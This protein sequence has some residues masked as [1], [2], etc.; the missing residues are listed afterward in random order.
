MKELFAVY[1]ESLDQD[2]RVFLNRDEAE[3]HMAEL[4][5]AGKPVKMQVFGSHQIVR[6]E[7][8]NGCSAKDPNFWEDLYYNN[9][10]Y[11]LLEHFSWHESPEEEG[12]YATYDLDV[13]QVDS[14]LGRIIFLK[15]VSSLYEKVC[16][17]NILDDI[18]KYTMNIFEQK[19]KSGI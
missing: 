18:L 16:A 19:L 17:E 2:L 1:I 14:I 13:A 10:T 4:K 15:N 12:Y 11:T 6:V 8:A 3:A 7:K 5:N 9:G